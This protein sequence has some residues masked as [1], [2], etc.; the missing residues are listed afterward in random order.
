MDKR[1]RLLQIVRRQM[2]RFLCRRHRSR[3][4]RQTG[5]QD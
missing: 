5:A 2:A 3:E 1:C 4:Q